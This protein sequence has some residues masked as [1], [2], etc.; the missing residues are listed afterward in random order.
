MAVRIAGL[1]VGVVLAGVALPDAAWAQSGASSQPTAGRGAA[2]V[3]P[4]EWASA[5]CVAALDLQTETLAAQVKAGRADLRGLLKA[6]LKAGAAFIGQAWLDGQ[7]D[8]GRS[9]ALLKQAQEAQ[10]SLPAP[11]LA[12]RQNRCAAEGDK[13][14]AD[15]NPLSRA[16]V[17]RLADKRMKKLLEG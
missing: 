9:Q 11:E 12:T 8:E 3:P 1:V 5:Q 7:R 4:R 10:R 14:L 2:Q 15:A 17:S 13:L 6:R 16:V